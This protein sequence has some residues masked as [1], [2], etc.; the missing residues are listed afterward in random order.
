MKP[1]TRTEVWSKMDAKEQQFMKEL[2]E[3]FGI[4]FLNGEI[5]SHGNEK[6]KVDNN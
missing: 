5:R 6:K 3:K 2:N 1:A 4:T